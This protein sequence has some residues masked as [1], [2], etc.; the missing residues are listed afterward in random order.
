MI[1]LA[2]YLESQLQFY[3]FL[4]RVIKDIAAWTVVHGTTGKTQW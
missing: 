2:L 3:N 4:E 1:V